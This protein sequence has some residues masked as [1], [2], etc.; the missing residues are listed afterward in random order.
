MIN[1]K[2]NPRFDVFKSELVEGASLVKIRA[3]IIEKGRL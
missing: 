2:K 3:A 1:Y